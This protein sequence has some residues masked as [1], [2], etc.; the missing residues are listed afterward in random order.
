M[1]DQVHVDGMDNL[2]IIM[3]TEMMFIRACAIRLISSDNENEPVKSKNS[4]T[5]EVNYETARRSH[6][7]MLYSESK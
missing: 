2:A 3:R 4:C 7:R 1:H 6:Y 5:R